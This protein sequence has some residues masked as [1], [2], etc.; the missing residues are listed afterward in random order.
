[1][2]LGAL[3]NR[4]RPK[5][6]NILGIYNWVII[7]GIPGNVLDKVVD[8]FVIPEK[9]EHVDCNTKTKNHFKYVYNNLHLSEILEEN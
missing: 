3:V 5:I 6:F 2:I 7:L 9:A 8:L 4:V 1:M